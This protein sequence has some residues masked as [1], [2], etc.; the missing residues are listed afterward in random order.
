MDPIPA[1]LYCLELF[2]QHPEP[3]KEHHRTM[4]FP[5]GWFYLSQSAQGQ[6]QSS[7][8]WMGAALCCSAPEQANGPWPI[9]FI[10]KDWREKQNLDTLC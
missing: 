3:A 1:V 7:A 9:S 6:E 10:N 4:I 5:C 2:Q 8:M